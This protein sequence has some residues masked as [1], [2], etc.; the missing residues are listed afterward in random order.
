MGLTG[1]NMR[2]RELAREIAKKPKKVEKPK[3]V[4]VEV[5]PKP[6][7]PIKVSVEKIK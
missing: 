5:K 7:K 4:K 3:E 6:V 2:R 1:H